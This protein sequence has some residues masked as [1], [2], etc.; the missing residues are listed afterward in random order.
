MNDSEIPKNGL[1]VPGKR[2][3]SLNLQTCQNGPC[4]QQGLDGLGAID[5]APQISVWGVCMFACRLLLQNRECAHI[6]DD[7]GHDI[8]ISHFSCDITCTNEFHKMQK[9]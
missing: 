3:F 9:I 4:N 5:A 6:R 7:F 1:L 8:M 2:G